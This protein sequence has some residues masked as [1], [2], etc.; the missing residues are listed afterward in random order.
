MAQTS[1]QLLRWANAQ[2]PTLKTRLASTYAAI[3]TARRILA[4]EEASRS[5]AA[6]ER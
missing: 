2:L 3:D 5:S 6:V 4:D 1:A